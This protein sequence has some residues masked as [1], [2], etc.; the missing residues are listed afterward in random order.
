MMWHLPTFTTC[1]IFKAM[2]N[3][4]GRIKW[5]IFFE[6]Y[7]RKTN[8]M[9]FEAEITIWSRFNFYFKLLE[10]GKY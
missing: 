10:Q 2:P 9:F 4:L 5:N 6:W 7:V 3:E 1:L 8:L